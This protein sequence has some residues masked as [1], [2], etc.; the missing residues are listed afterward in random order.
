MDMSE[1]VS[2]PLDDVLVGGGQGGGIVSSMSTA[3]LCITCLT[4][5]NTQS[6]KYHSLKCLSRGVDGMEPS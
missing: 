1:V 6:L 3:I 4:L 5:V 2:S